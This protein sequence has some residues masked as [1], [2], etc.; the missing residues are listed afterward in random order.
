MFIWTHNFRIKSTSVL[1]VHAHKGL[2]VCLF[3]HNRTEINTAAFISM[4]E[5]PDLHVCTGV[6]HK[7]TAQYMKT[8]IKN[9]AEVTFFQRLQLNPW[10]EGFSGNSTTLVKNSNSQC[11]VLKQFLFLKRWMQVHKLIW[12]I[13]PQRTSMK[14]TWSYHSNWTIMNFRHFEKSI[15]LKS[16][17]LLSLLPFFLTPPF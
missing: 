7:A 8:W 14:Y 16:S 10:L 3:E 4:C 5:N 2:H 6:N 11:Q 13:R 1:R 17:I 12:K 9:R 15:K